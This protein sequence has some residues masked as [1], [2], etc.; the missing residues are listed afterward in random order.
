MPVVGR[1][2]EVQ[3]SGNPLPNVRNVGQNIG[4]VTGMDL[5]GIYVFR[6]TISN[7]ICP[8]KTADVTVDVREKTTQSWAR[9]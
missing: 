6:Y 3:I 1:G 5:P 2:R 8:D 9:S 7:G 4:I